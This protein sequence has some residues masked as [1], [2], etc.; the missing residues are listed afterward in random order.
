MRYPRADA[1]QIF[2]DN[3]PIESFNLTGLRHNIGVVPRE[4]ILFGGTIA[5][6]ISYGKPGAGGAEIREAARKAN[7]LDFILSFPAGL[8]T[9]VGE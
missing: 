5:G 7:A 1:G 8:Q 9:L 6:N 3:Q 2:V 4:V